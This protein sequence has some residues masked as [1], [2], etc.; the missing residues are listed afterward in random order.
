[1]I[2]LQWTFMIHACH[3]ILHIITSLFNTKLLSQSVT[4]YY[5]LSCCSRGTLTYS[6]FEWV[7]QLIFHTMQYLTV[8]NN[9]QPGASFRYCYVHAVCAHCCEY[10]GFA[11]SSYAFAACSLSIAVRWVLLSLTIIDRVTHVSAGGWHIN[12]ISLHMYVLPVYSY[13]D[14]VITLGLNNWICSNVDVLCLSLYG[15]IIAGKW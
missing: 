6:I 15:N 8:Y 9:E 10:A 2:V 14:I 12:I 13:I 7:M 3:Y 5:Y 1:M 11:S 4:L